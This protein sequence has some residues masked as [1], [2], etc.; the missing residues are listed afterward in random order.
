ML[1]S[2]ATIWFGSLD[3]PGYLTTERACL[4]YGRAMFKVAEGENQPADIVAW[5]GINSFR[6]LNVAGN[7]ESRTPGIEAMVERFLV[8]VFRKLPKE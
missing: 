3:S 4:E 6:T 7:R 8:A 2:S 1:E 5:L